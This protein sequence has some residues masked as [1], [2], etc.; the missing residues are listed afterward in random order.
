[1]GGRIHVSSECAEELKKFGKE[2][3]LVE[4]K[5]QVMCKGKGFLS[6]AWLEIPTRSSDGATVETVHLDQSERL[7]AKLKMKEAAAVDAK[8]L[9]LVDWN[10]ENLQR[11]LLQIAARRSATEQQSKSFLTASEEQTIDLQLR[12]GKMVFDEVA[13]VITLPKYDHTVSKADALKDST[14]TLSVEV[15]QQLREFVLAISSLYRSSNPFHNFDHASHVAMS[16]QKLLSRI[17][18]PKLEEVV[19]PGFTQDLEL[20]KKLHGTS[21]IMNGVGFPNLSA[22]M[23]SLTLVTFPPSLLKIIPAA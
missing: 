7:A 20:Q 11:L 21:I 1:M 8:T 12:Q 4:R 14:E 16:V 23:P 22:Y 19:T 13:E 3:W 6:T 17:V 2:D 18:A 5:D 9:R 10:T 15:L